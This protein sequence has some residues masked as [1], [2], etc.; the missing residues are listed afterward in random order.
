[1]IGSLGSMASMAGMTL[2]PVLTP[3]GAIQLVPTYGT[4]AAAAVAAATAA[5][6]AAAAAAHSAVGPF[7]SSMADHQ[8]PTVMQQMNSSFAR[9][10]T[11]LKVTAARFAIIHPKS[12]RPTGSQLDQPFGSTPF[13]CPLISFIS[14]FLLF[15]YLFLGIVLPA[16]VVFIFI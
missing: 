2:Q 16:G 6:A 3:S 12:I 1:M 9:N 8:P 5:A 4:V 14:F 11:R 10:S 15:I 7:T 13:Y